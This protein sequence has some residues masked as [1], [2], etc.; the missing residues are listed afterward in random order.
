MHGCLGLYKMVFAAGESRTGTRGA[1]RSSEQQRILQDE[2]RILR[3]GEASDQRRETARR[4]HIR[5]LSDHRLRFA[6][7]RERGAGRDHRLLRRAAAAPARRK[8]APEIAGRGIHVWARAHRLSGSWRAHHP[9][10]AAQARKDPG[11]RHP[12]PGP[13]RAPL[14]GRAGGGLHLPVPRA[15]IGAGAP[16]QGRGRARHDVGL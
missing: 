8:R 10:S 1:H 2:C 16:P 14:D 3:Y 5:R 15:S 6:S 4:P 11:R 9:L 13:S 12:P 7:L